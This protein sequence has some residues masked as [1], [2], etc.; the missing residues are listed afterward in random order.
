MGTKA[1]VKGI[2]SIP[3]PKMDTHK[4]EPL[5]SSRHVIL[6]GG[7][8]ARSPDVEYSPKVDYQSAL[9]MAGEALAAGQGAI[10]GPVPFNHTDTVDRCEVVYRNAPVLKDLI[11]AA[12]LLRGK[13]KERQVFA[14]VKTTRI[15]DT[16]KKSLRLYWC[17]IHCA[18]FINCGD[19]PTRDALQKVE[20]EVANKLMQLTSMT[21]S[22]GTGLVVSTIPSRVIPSGIE[23]VKEYFMPFLVSNIWPHSNS[24]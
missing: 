18:L 21:I 12:G 1:F 3:L 10:L 8:L 24:Q 22:P 19:V 11:L 20:S 15:H 13:L 5:G 2:P 14:G 4:V 17:S 23:E 7:P 6:G 9:K 16:G